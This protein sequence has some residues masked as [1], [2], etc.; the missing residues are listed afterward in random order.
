MYKDWIENSINELGFLDYF[1]LADLCDKS[2]IITNA[3]FAT[4][5]ENLKNC[6]K[7]YISDSNKQ[8]R[9]SSYRVFKHDID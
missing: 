1:E 9:V 4:I 2:E 3:H 5:I 6:G 8:F 7:S